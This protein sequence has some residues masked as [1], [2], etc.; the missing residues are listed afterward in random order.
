M[1]TLVAVLA[2]IIVVLV[3]AKMVQ[4]RRRDEIRSIH[5][6]HDRLDTLHV[7][8]SDR[9]GSVRVVREPH[10]EDAPTTPERP[11]LDPAS[12]HL[13]TTPQPLPAEAPAR[14]DR[15][16]ALERMQ[17][18]ARVDTATILIVATVIVALIAIALV[19]YAIQHRRGT[20][21]TTTTTKPAPTGTQTTAH[22]AH[23]TEGGVAF[24]SAPTAHLTVTVIGTHGHVWVFAAAPASSTPQSRSPRAGQQRLDSTRQ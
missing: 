10:A 13:D 24:E 7:E 5:H 1:D 18:R 2:A 9:G 21:T 8:P 17:A 15:S 16:W 6:Y 19:G 23:S 3:G 12:A 4:R 11:R 14:H 20:S 22:V